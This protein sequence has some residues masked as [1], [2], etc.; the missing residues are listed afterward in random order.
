MDFGTGVVTYQ[1]SDEARQP[2]SFYRKAGAYVLKQARKGFINLDND[3][4]SPR[5]VFQ[6]ALIPFQAAQERERK[7]IKPR[8]I[9]FADEEF[10]KFWQSTAVVTKYVK[11]ITALPYYDIF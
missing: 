10:R 7:A 8:E 6:D 4:T 3:I 11:E 5:D 2:H 9:T 1:P